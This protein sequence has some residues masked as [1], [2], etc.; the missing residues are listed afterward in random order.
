MQ[1]YKVKLLTGHTAKTDQLY[2]KYLGNYAYVGVGLFSRAEALKKAIMFG[3][4]IEKHGKNY[5]TEKLK[6]IQLSKSEL[7]PVIVG[8]LENREIFDDAD[9][10]LH[11]AL[12]CGTV[13]NDILNEQED[14]AFVLQF[15]K[16]ILDELY[17]LDIM[18][19]GYDYIMIVE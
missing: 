4:K 2:G 15:N 14:L 19:S 17:T 5:T 3:G 8:E 10:N 6:L 7:N 16:D 12:F 13:F 1:L 11:Q 9:T 18:V